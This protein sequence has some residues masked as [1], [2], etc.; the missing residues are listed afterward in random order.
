MHRGVHIASIIGMHGC[1]YIGMDRG[2]Y[3]A[4]IIGINRGVENPVLQACIDTSVEPVL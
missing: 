2:I 1:V 3:I 4:S